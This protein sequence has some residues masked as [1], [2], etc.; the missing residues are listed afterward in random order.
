MILQHSLGFTVADA[1]KIDSVET[2]DLA[3]RYSYQ[4][5]KNT[6]KTGQSALL[7]FNANDT[8]TIALPLGYS[9]ADRCRFIGKVIGTL[10]L[11]IT[12]PTLGAQIIT[13]KD[14]SFTISMRMSSISL[15][16]KAGK[17]ATLQWSMF[18]MLDSNSEDFQ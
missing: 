13:L 9:S 2:S 8:K 14:G 11:T 17:S 15:T 7:S 18:Q 5:K 4:V 10:E 6:S 3:F 1:D 16:E 12:H